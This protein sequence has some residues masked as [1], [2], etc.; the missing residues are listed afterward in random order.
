MEVPITG[1][2]GPTPKHELNPRLCKFLYM[3]LMDDI[4]DICIIRVSFSQVI[5]FQLHLFF[6]VIAFF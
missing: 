1:V 2:D 6:L 3:G 5:K 4:P